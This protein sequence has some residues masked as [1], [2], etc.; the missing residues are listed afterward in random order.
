MACQTNSPRTAMNTGD[1]K[2]SGVMS[3]LEGLVFRSRTESHFEVSIASASPAWLSF[4]RIVLR[5]F[6]EAKIQARKSQGVVSG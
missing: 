3:W 1:K 4:S 6:Q 2:A 5:L